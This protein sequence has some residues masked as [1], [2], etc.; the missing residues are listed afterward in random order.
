MSVSKKLMVSLFGLILFVGI[1]V[2]ARE[3]GEFSNFRITSS[4]TR[5]GFLTKQNNNGNYVINL[6]PTRGNYRVKNVL[7]NSA[8]AN[9]SSVANDWVGHRYEHS[10]WGSKGYIYS[11]HMARENW[12]DSA[13]AITGSWS[14]DHK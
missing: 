9:R 12:W 1:V 3:I 11:L 2:E 13:V 4:Y 6:S 8:D 5:T 14:P 7:R 10:T